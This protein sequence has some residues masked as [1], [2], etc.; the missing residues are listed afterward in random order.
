MKITRFLTAQ[1]ALFSLLFVLGILNSHAE[2]QISVTLA[3][4]NSTTPGTINL[5]VTVNGKGFK[6]GARAQWFVT[7]TTN[8]GGVN[9][10]ST[11]FVSSTALTANITVSDTA[12]LGNF[13]IQVTNSDGRTGKGTELFAINPNGAKSSGCPTPPE[14]IPVVNAC[15]SSTPQTACIDPNFVPPGYVGR[16]ANIT[17]VP[18]LQPQADGT[19]R[20]VVATG[21]CC[22][23]VLLRYNLDGTPD[24]TFGANGN[25]T[26]TLPYSTFAGDG[27]GVWGAV[28]DRNRNIV[29][30]ALPTQPNGTGSFVVV[31]FT[32]D[33]SLDP[34]FATNGVF[35]YLNYQAF[36]LALQPDGKIVIGGADAKGNAKL[37]RFTANGALD[38]TFGSGGVAAA[39]RGVTTFRSVAIQTIGNT[40][41][42]LASTT[43][44]FGR[45]TPAGALDSSFGSNGQVAA[46]TCSA[47]ARAASIYVDPSGGIYTLGG[48]NNDI[49]LSKYTPSGTFDTTFGALN[50]NGSGHTGVTVLNINGQTSNP[51]YSSS[52]AATTNGTGVTQLIA[53]GQ[54]NASGLTSTLVMRF[55]LD[56]SLDPT[57]GVAARN[58]GSSSVFGS[59]VLVDPTGGVVSSMCQDLGSAGCEVELTRYWP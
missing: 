16:P 59:G 13:D 35:T 2:A 14:I 39:P 43:G 32:P 33:G 57:F 52:L 51:G 24:A 31:R 11:K 36:G 3:T 47:V 54:G 46:L 25:G 27:V 29:V 23:V 9:V 7:G 30:L 8:P 40:S 4:P 17:D 48:L 42:I 34:T 1:T 50:L 20:I 10:N 15:T 37:F 6:S 19:Q 49:A 38:S 18:R 21:D 41:Y 28:I 58:P 26:A 22:N 5:D 44:W 56:G 55:N 12:V 45:F 53:V